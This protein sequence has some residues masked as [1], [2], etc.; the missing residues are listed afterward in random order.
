MVM[1]DKV[2]VLV[3]CATATEAETI[4]REVVGR[5]LAACVNILE[6]PVR[7]IYRWNDRVENAPE[8]L[9]LIKTSK[10]LMK[11][12]QESIEQIHS[13]DVPELIALQIGD[14]SPDYLRWLEDAIRIP[15]RPHRARPARVAPT[16]EQIEQMKPL[17]LLPD[18]TLG[19][20]AI[21]SPEEK[22]K[23]ESGT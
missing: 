4:A 18:E 23:E 9:L 1:K 2:V 12:L 8:H 15:R 16:P 11:P 3:T 5:R 22:K 21:E 17:D 20:E 13:Y 19:K 7:S 14:G 6:S 10:K